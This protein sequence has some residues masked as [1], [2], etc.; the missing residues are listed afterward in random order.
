MKSKAL[1]PTE[2]QNSGFQSRN[3]A[4]AASAAATSH[5]HRRAGL[6]ARITSTGQ[7]SQAVCP[8]SAAAFTALADSL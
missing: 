1:V 7:I 8:V 4:A 6:N 2:A 3:A 5:S